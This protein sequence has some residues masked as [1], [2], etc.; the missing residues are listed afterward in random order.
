MTATG[1]S[2]CIREFAQSR[3]QRKLA[4]SCPV[5]TVVTFADIG[6]VNAGGVRKCLYARVLGFEVS[7]RVI[8]QYHPHIL[9][10]HP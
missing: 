6:D 4:D 3:E 7:R 9:S 5:D 8:H 1:G 2:G 10:T